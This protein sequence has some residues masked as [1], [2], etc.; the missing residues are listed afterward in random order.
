M[1][2]AAIVVAGGRGIRMKASVN[3]VFLQ[4]GGRPILEW[5]LELFERCPTVDQVIVV[6]NSADVATCSS[7][8]SRFPKVSKVVAGGDLRHRSEFAGIAALSARIDAGEVETVLVHD[9]VRPFA[10]PGL[11]R[12][13]LDGMTTSN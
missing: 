10:S 9:A 12:G 13:L 7:L 5:S 2:A 11:V 6:A 3:K 8:K 4:V 1:S